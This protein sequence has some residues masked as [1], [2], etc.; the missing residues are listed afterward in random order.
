[1]RIPFLRTTLAISLAA[2]S[3]YT[4]ANGLAINEQSASG[5]GTAYAGRA[6]SALDAST[7][8]GNPAGLS[9]LKGTQVSG[10]MAAVHANVDIKQTGGTARGSNKG[11]MV[12]FAAVPF[13]YFA[14]EIDENW[15]FGL[16]VY[17]PFGVISDYEKGFAG[18]SQGLYSEVRVITM[19]PTI[20][21]KFNDRIAVGFG[22]TINRIDGELTRNVNFDNVATAAQ[23]SGLP[24]RPD[25]PEGKSKVKGD[26]MG[27]GYNLGVMIDLSDRTTW[28]LTYHS[29]V[30]YKLKGD[31]TISGVKQDPRYPLLPL[32]E[33]GKFKGSLDFTTP[34]SIDT[35]VTHKLNDQWT[36]HAGATWTRWSRLEN[37]EPISK[38]GEVDTSSSKEELKWADTWSFSAGAEYQL[39]P[40]VALRAGLAWDESPTNNK[41]RNVRIPVSDRMIFGMGVGWKATDNLTVDAAYAYIKERE[42]KVNREE[43]FLSANG[44]PSTHQSYSAKYKNSA[45]GLTASATYRF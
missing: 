10:G 14:T 42:G 41:Y 8:Y 19:Q 4:L 2:A 35:S 29:K 30:K 45:H 38:Y 18:R 13:G 37:I 34:E 27:Y 11:D 43:T 12:P 25:L 44:K 22:P 31:I 15:A 1:M 39:N 16:G 20:S 32:P 24:F 17:V 21:Y 5:A 36:V 28:G 40:T 23:L 33:N 9:K 7:I 6:S 26:D 3:T